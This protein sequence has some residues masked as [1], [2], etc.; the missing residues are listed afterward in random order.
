M[1]SCELFSSI[2]ASVV[3][4]TVHLCYFL[5]SITHRAATGVTN[6]STA[7]H[8]SLLYL[9]ADPLASK[10]ENPTFKSTDPQDFRQSFPELKRKLYSAINQAEEG[11]LGISLPEGLI[12]QTVMPEGLP[13]QSVAFDPIAL[14]IEYEVVNPKHGVRFVGGD[15]DSVCAFLLSTTARILTV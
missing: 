10:P 15:D 13:E 5:L 4:V 14:T 9:H 6:V 8:P 3:S 1:P 12:K 7:D 11:E 2:A